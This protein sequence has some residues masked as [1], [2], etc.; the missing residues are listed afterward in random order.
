MAKTAKKRNQAAPVAFKYVYG[1]LVEQTE[2]GLYRDALTRERYG[3]SQVER[4]LR[5]EELPADKEADLARLRTLGVL[6]PAGQEQWRRTHR[7]Q[8]RLGANA[9]HEDRAGLSRGTPRGRRTGA[10][11][12]YRQ[13]SLRRSATRASIAG[14]EGRSASSCPSLCDDRFKT[15]FAASTLS[16]SLRASTWRPK[17]CSPT[18]AG[19][20]W[21]ASCW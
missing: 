7:C 9:V 3:V 21:S 19:R 16:P 5:G 1:E 11:Q 17:R 6:P 15:F 10:G 4:R 13:R 18:R 12:D 20:C 14:L 2:E 8:C